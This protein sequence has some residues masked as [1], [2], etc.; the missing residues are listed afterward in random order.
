LTL[1]IYPLMSELAWN[2]S[3]KLFYAHTIAGT[4]TS[5]LSDWPNVYSFEFS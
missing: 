2:W 1:S 3:G 5:I 4:T